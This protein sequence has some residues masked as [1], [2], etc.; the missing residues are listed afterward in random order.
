M[1][2]VSKTGLSRSDDNIDNIAEACL[3]LDE[4]IKFTL[5][6]NWLIIIMNDDIQFNEYYILTNKDKSSNLSSLP[7]TH[8]DTLKHLWHD[9]VLLAFGEGEGFH[10][11]PVFFP[12]QQQTTDTQSWKHLAVNHLY[13]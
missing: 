3:W 13:L 8:A 1:V 7:Y 12:L 9:R 11:T 2:A 10:I 6:Y 5:I 4:A